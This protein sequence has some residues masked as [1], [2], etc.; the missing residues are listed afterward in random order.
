MLRIAGRRLSSLSWR[1]NQTASAITSRN[2]INGE[3]A[4]DDDSRSPSPHHGFSSRYT[5]L[6]PIRG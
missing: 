1:Q 6:G 5:Y 3:A 4:S 2:L